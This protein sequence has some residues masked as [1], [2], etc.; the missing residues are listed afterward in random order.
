M[1]KVI[2]K[3]QKA[4]EDSLNQLLTDVNQNKKD[5]QRLDKNLLDRLTQS[6]GNLLDDEDLITVLAST[7]TQAQEVSVKL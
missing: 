5:L 2:S 3:E 7:K 6:Q 1:G 4:L